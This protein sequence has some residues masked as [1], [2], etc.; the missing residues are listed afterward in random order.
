MLYKCAIDPPM[1]RLRLLLMELSRSNGATIKLEI[2]TLIMA[3]LRI[4]DADVIFLSCFYLSFSP[5]LISAVADWM[6]T[7][8]FYTHGV[9]LY[10]NLGCRSETCC[11]RLA[12][13]AGRKKSQKVTI[14]APSYTTLSG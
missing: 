6:P 5:R 8:Y 2:D 11:T 9:A 13:N 7:P 1:P 12:G 10:A 4:A 14:C 3:A